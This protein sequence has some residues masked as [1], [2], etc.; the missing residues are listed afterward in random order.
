MPE[1][2]ITYRKFSDT[3]LAIA[4]AIRLEEGEV[5]YQLEDNSRLFDPNFAN[6]QL[7]SDISIKLRPVDFVKADEVLA[8]FYKRSLD[9]IDSDYYLLAFTDA[10][11]MEVV[12][13]PDE[14]GPFDYQLAM[15]L[16]KERGQEV[17][18][19]EAER[20]KQQRMKELEVPERAHRNLIITGYICILLLVIVGIAIGSGLVFYKK[21]L[22][23]GRRIFAFSEKDRG[24]GYIILTLSIVFFV[25]SLLLKT[26]IG[27]LY[28]IF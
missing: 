11:L 24:H 13:R 14:W 26:Y 8:D 9:S 19:E 15:K 5:A 1:R 10:E 27:V 7:D 6:N 28:I 4:I 3:G 22:P 17:K 20:L 2:F 16:L 18:P 12:A 21:T 25:F 23:D